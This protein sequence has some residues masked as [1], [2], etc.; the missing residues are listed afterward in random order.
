MG[1]NA[2]RKSFKMRVEMY[3][4]SSLY[5]TVY[6]HLFALN[7]LETF[8]DEVQKEVMCI[9]H[10]RKCKCRLKMNRKCM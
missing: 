10:R 9:V 4:C 2:C 7:N 5:I 8:C 6:N 1:N 3:Y